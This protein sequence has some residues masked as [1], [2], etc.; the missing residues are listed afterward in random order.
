MPTL[1]SASLCAFMSVILF[2]CNTQNTTTERSEEK[3]LGT[4]SQAIISKHESMDLQTYHAA[5]MDH[6]TQ[7]FSVS[8][9]NVSVLKAKGG[10]KITV[11]PST[12][13]REDG[14]KT[15]GKI[16][17]SIIELT[18]VQDLF[19]CNAATISN[20]RLLA[21]GGSYYVGM[22]NN[23]VKMKIKNGQSMQVSFP[24]L[25]ED[26][27]ELFYGRRNALNDM[28]WEPANVLLQKQY[29]SISFTDDN[30]F[31]DYPQN[32]SISLYEELPKAK[33]YK[34]LDE[35][36]Y[37]YKTKMT[38]SKLVDTINKK[39]QKVYLQ[40]ISFWPKNLP[41]DQVLDTHYLTSL[42][43]PR[44][45]YILKRCGDA[46]REAA[47]KEE[48]AAEASAAAAAYAARPPK[49]LARQLQK[50]YTDT[51]VAY[52]GW[53]NGDRFIDDPSQKTD[54]ELDLPYTFNNGKIEYFVLFK[55]INSLLNE[56]MDFNDGEKPVLR[57]LPA[58]QAVT[59]IAFIKKNGTIY[60]AKEDFVVGKK[61]T[62]KLAF[63]EISAS[64]MNKMF[65]SNAKT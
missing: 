20:G 22:E 21:S 36:V 55:S 37:F 40:T 44:L 24:L 65:G 61:A 16:D 23:S 5:Y 12:L 25:K 62:Q 18:N 31:A 15:E 50:Y 6:A 42:Y 54:T 19:R 7:H 64:E 4:I 13:E 43:G 53:I 34:S 29:E 9:K 57:N 52:L 2:S 39:E 26:D 3:Q 58:G 38:L 46:E 47:A 30:R 10:L 60:H 27:M 32:N 33:V 48:R 59:L 17:V 45:Q 56:R 14:A 63:K 35:A 28:N 41:T 49:S 51:D 1:R 8:A 11:D